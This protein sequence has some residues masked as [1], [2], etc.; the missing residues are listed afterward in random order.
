MTAPGPLRQRK[1]A[2]SCDERGQ[3]LAE[4]AIVLPFLLLIILVIIQL[5]ILIW[6]Y[7]TVSNMAR[8][9]A[10]YAIVRPGAGTDFTSKCPS[11]VAAPATS[12][13]EAACLLGTGLDLAEAGVEIDFSTSGGP[14]GNVTVIVTYPAEI[15]FGKIVPGAPD[16]VDLQST[17]TMAREQ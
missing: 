6:N 9:G 8:E 13:V 3:D 17:A 11:S 1:V 5:G 7:N 15:I 2:L 10:R 14:L 16:T 12:I 4:F